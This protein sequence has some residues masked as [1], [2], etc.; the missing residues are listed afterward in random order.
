MTLPRPHTQQ[1]TQ[2]LAT[3]APLVGG[4]APCVIDLDILQAQA[5]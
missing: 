5:N 1:L 3:L 4:F 2:V